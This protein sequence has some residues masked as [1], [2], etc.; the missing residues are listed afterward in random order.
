MSGRCLPS[1]TS[2]SSGYVAGAWIVCS[3]TQAMESTGSWVRWA[4]PRVRASFRCVTRRWPRSWLAA[5]RSSPARSECVSRHQGLARSICSTDCTTRRQMA[6]RCWRSLVSNAGFRWGRAISRRSTYRRC[7]RTY[8]SSF[9][10]P[11]LRAQARHLVDRAV[12]TSLARGGVTTLVFPNDVQ[13]TGRG[14]L[15]AERPRRGFLEHRRRA[16]DTVVPYNKP[17]S[18]RQPRS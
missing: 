7:S 2:F 6:S 12:R 9:K 3:G 18:M 4:V 14:D 15:A 8:R 16:A 5:M 13:E 10:R 11:L 17:R 1:L